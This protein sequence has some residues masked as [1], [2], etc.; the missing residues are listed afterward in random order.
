MQTF[1]FPL[2]STLPEFAAM[3]LSLSSAANVQVQ[4]PSILLC[5]LF[6][7]PLPATGPEPPHPYRT[8]VIK[9]LP[10]SGEDFYVYTPPGYRP[11]ETRRY[12]VLYLLHGWGSPA[13]AWI[14]SG[15]ANL[16]I[17]NLIAEGQ[18]VPMIVVMP[19][20]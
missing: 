13:E 5:S 17:D 20:G 9:G 11:A 6:A 2:R 16:I 10:N 14:H 3:L 4:K 7:L 8:N 19:L 15:K 18:A 1:R 12:P